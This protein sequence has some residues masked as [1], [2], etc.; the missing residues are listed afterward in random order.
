MNFE[1]THTRVKIHMEA[2]YYST[3]EQ[4][5]LESARTA[6]HS[7]VHVFK[8]QRMPSEH[9]AHIAPRKA[10]L[11][12]NTQI[13]HAPVQYLRVQ[14]D[15]SKLQGSMPLITMQATGYYQEPVRFT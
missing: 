7:A 11:K 15:C 14:R 6:N 5:E 3:H 8:T 2:A 1:Y 12:V 9:Y 13:L 10:W 4:R